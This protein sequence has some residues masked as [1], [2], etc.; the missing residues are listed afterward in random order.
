M[1]H[2]RSQ[3]ISS[4]GCV[5][6]LTAMRLHIAPLGKNSAASWP[7]SSATRPHSAFTVGS[8]PRC[9]SP[10]GAAA[11]ASRIAAVGRVCVSL[12]RL[13][14]SPASLLLTPRRYG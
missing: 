14:I 2:S 4:P 12:Y 9:S 10:T 6:V 1:W 5:C 11:I 7:N 3:M 13:T 8:A